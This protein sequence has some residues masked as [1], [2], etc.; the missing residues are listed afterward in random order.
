MFLGVAA[1]M[2]SNPPEPL[3]TT[4]QR[5]RASLPDQASSLFPIPCSSLLLD[6]SMSNPSHVA[7][8]VASCASRN[9]FEHSERVPSDGACGNYCPSRPSDPWPIPSWAE[10]ANRL[11]LH[12]DA[13]ANS[14]TGGSSEVSIGVLSWYVTVK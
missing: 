3:G 9:D 11:A 14:T 8:V 5:Q 4:L 13:S 10:N 6:G 12:S 7:V 2:A 1:S